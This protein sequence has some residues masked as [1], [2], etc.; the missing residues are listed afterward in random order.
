[1]STRNKEIGEFAE[2]WAGRGYEKGEAVKF[3]EELQDALGYDDKFATTYEAH[4]DNGGYVDAW[5]HEASTIVEQKS[6]GVDLDKPEPRQGR[7]KTPLEQALDYVDELRPSE[8]PR[9]VITCNF[10]TFRVYDRDEC[11]RSQLAEHAHEFTLSELGEH[12]ERLGFVTDHAN[13]RIEHEKQISIKAG[14]RVGQLYDRLRA[15]Y[16]DPDSPDS[17]HSLNV[18]CVRIVFCLFCEDSELFERSAFYNY[19][20][21]YQAQHVRK[22]L[23]ALFRALDTPVGERDPYDTELLSFPYV[24]GGLFREEVEVPP[25]DEGTRAFLLEDLSADVD[26]SEISPTIFGG[27]FEGTLNPE[28]RRSG[29]MHYTSPENIHRVIDPLFLDGLRDELSHIQSATGVTPRRRKAALRDLHQRVCRMNF[30]DPACGSGNFLTETYICLRRLEDAILRDLNDGQRSV[31]FDEGDGERVSLAQFHGIEIND[32]AVTVAE[33]ALWISRLKANGESMMTYD[34]SANDFPLREKA[35]I[36]HGN[37]LRMDWNEVLPAGR[38]SYIMGNPPFR[39]ARWQTK[40]QK[41]ELQEAFHHAK[42]SGNVDY[43][44]GWYVKAADYMAGWPI[45]A[46]FVS[47][48]SICQGEQVA[49]VWKPLYD[50]GVRIDFAHDTFRWSNEATGQAHVFVIIVGFSKLGGTK[51]LFHHA[52]PDAEEETMHPGNINAYLLDAPDVFVCGRGTPLSKVPPIGIGSQPIDDGSYLFKDEEIREFLDKEPGAAQYVHP[53]LGSAEFLNARKRWTLWLGNASDEELASLPLCRERIELVRAFRLSSKRTQ[54]KKAAERPKNYGTEILL[55][56]MA[57]VI[58]QVSSERRPYIPIGF[59]A[60]DVFCSDKLR[61]VPGATLYHFGVLHSQFHNAW[62]RR[63]TGRLKNDYQYTNSIVYN[64]FIWPEPSDEQR[65]AIEECAQAVLDAR[66]NHPGDS[67]AALYDPD[68]MPEDLLTAHKALDS[69]VEAAY[70]VDFGGDE[71]KI[72]AHLFKL[73]AEKV[74]EGH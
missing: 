2:R 55:D 64:C 19:V 63:T 15:C 45:R 73:Y 38:C 23:L 14:E 59:I 68:K 56:S 41:A 29:G 27:I 32:F 7:M 58:P 47:T 44:A 5:L 39:G 28:T 42:N 4:L 30:F 3:W 60:P 24:N 17:L 33:T 21:A 37:A 16:A 31:A 54:T 25:I 13:A 10:S 51:T 11:S 34:V 20:S 22:A 53:W 36:V 18:L 26:W 62:M 35:N 74:G 6:L 70:G 69:A 65:R 46:A 67:L 49:N 9:F 48:N 43:V 50:L 12:P 8:Q 52:C 66:D 40:E 57:V 1:M 61:V 71:E 72:V